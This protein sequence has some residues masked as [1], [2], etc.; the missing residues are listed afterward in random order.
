MSADGSEITYVYDPGGSQDAVPALL[1]A[2]RG[3]GVRVKDLE[4]SQSSL[5]DIF[6]NLVREVE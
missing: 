5:E 3:A 2:L 1:E 4:T 6:V